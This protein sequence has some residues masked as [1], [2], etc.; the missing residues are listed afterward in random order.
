MAWRMRIVTDIDAW[1]DLVWIRRQWTGFMPQRRPVFGMRGPVGVP[2]LWIAHA[3]SFI[4][5]PMRGD[6]P[7]KQPYA[8]VCQTAAYAQF[9]YG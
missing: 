9:C 5:R 3:D 1:A 6:R 8:I 2:R 7:R 4:Y